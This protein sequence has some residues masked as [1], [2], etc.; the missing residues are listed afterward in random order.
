MKR[1]CF[2]PGTLSLG[3]IGKLFIN[4]IE[5]YT[6]R[7]IPVDLF[8]TKKE[9]EFLEQI[10]ENVR[11]F[12]G[13]GRASASIR[14]FINY[15][16]KEKP[17]AVISA[18]EYLNIVNIVCCATTLNRTKA[19]VSLHTNQTA[20]NY[21]SQHKSALLYKKL[22][23]KLMA[24]LLYKLPSKIIAVSEGVADDFALR[25]GVNRKNIEVIYNPVYKP[26]DLGCESVET[27]DLR[28]KNLNKR[29]VIGVGRL[30][31]QKDFATLIEAFYLLRQKEDISLVILGEG[32]LREELE[33]QI[34]Q[35]SLS[36]HVLLLGFVSNPLYYVR[37]ASALVV[38]SKFEGF[39]NTIVEALGVGTPVVSTNCPSGPDEILQ[40]GKYGILVPTSDPDK[41][42]AAL[43]QI[44]NNVSF[45]KKELIT[46]AEDFAVAKIADKY[47]SYIEAV[48]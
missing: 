9:G 3:G 10:P 8:L 13:N 15:L 46:R 5:E 45:Q 21:Y 28:F 1:I 48:K 6:S 11:V 17:F 32:P 29:F 44:L 47:L 30:T 16:H 4:L 39:G 35:L 37:R 20:E 34:N 33:Q 12:E 24:K 31:Q 2:F 22:H 7:G 25:M 36:D 23:F 27:V 38:S 26:Y 43:A 18:R 42:A 40:N 41:M 19:V 14:S